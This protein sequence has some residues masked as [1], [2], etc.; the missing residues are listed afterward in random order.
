MV[1]ER[2]REDTFKAP[3]DNLSEFGTY[4]AFTIKRKSDRYIFNEIGSYAADLDADFRTKN[5]SDNVTHMRYGPDLSFE[6]CDKT[7]R[8]VELGQLQLTIDDIDP[9]TG[10]LKCGFGV[11]VNDFKKGVAFEH[12]RRDL[13]YVNNNS[14]L[15]IKEISLNG[16]ILSADPSGNL[17]WNGKKLITET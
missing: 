15:F 3:E 16:G 5:P 17:L 7:N 9:E 1:C 14:R 11:Q 10:Y 2:I 4:S 6:V 13:L 8:S 12:V